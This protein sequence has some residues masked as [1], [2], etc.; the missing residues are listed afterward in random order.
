MIVFVLEYQRAMV[1]VFETRQLA[2]DYIKSMEAKAPWRE[3]RHD[4]E[5][6]ATSLNTGCM[7][8][9]L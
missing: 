9:W 8:V 2:E 5:I 4:F 1:G 7:G 3:I 6:R